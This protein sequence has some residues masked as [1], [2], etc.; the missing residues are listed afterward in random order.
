LAPECG[1][2]DGEELSNT[3]LFELVQKTIKTFFL[4]TDEGAK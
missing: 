4:L 2:Y 1:A 3:L